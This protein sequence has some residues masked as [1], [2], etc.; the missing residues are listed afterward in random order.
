[1]RPPSERPL[2]YPA[3]SQADLA[4]ERADIVSTQ[5]YDWFSK[6]AYLAQYGVW[7]VAPFLE[8]FGEFPPSQRVASFSSDQMIE[9]LQNSLN[10]K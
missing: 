7:R 1:L 5:Y 10:T 3:R 9:S 2:K 8:T 4:P 6:N